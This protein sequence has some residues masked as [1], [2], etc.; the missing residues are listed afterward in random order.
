MRKTKKCLEKCI[1]VLA[2]EINKYSITT[3]DK[4]EE[5]C[6]NRMFRAYSRFQEVY[7]S[8]YGKP[9]TIIE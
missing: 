3:V 9:Y 7:K 4:K 8:R 2:E 5:E 6:I 1:A